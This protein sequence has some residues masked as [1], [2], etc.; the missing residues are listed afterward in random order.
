[1]FARLI[2]VNPGFEP[3]RLISFD[4]SPPE[5]AYAEDD[6]RLRLEKQLRTQI[7]GLPGVDSAAI[8]YGL[9]FGTMLNATCG[10]RVEGWVDSEPR[11][12]GAIAWRVVSPGYFETMGVRVLAGRPFAEN[13]DRPDSLPVAIVNHTFALKYFPNQNPVDHRIQVLGISTN[14][15]QVVG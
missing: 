7:G 10:V 4:V 11:P 13:V 9:P 15:S 14:L 2:R 1:S 6:K 8:V 3:A 5:F 12:K